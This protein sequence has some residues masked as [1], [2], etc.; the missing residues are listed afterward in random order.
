MTVQYPD[1]NVTF[2]DIQERLGINE[3]LVITSIFYTLQGEG[4]LAGKPAV[5]I[6]TSGCNRGS[7]EDCQFCDTYFSLHN[8][9]VMSFGEIEQE[10]IKCAEEKLITPL[11]PWI[12]LTGGE[13]MIQPQLSPFLSYMIKQQGWRIQ[14]ESNGDF[15]SP[16]W[17]FFDTRNILLVVSPKIGHNQKHYSSIK[18]N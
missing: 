8:G 6:R 7:K 18:L 10:V 11:K 9:V 5:F 2:K 3:G 13:P 1:R 12:V 16:N 14:I 4:P 17:S 15:L